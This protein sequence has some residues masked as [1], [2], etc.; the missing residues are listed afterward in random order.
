MQIKVDVIPILIKQRH[1]KCVT[2]LKCSH[3][4]S[5]QVTLFDYGLHKIEAVEIYNPER[6]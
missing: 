2:T 3:N 4:M 1:V 6:E 5:H